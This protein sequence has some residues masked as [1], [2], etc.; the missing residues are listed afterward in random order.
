MLSANRAGWS[1]GSRLSAMVRVYRR[2]VN[3]DRRIGRIS[4]LALAG[5]FLTLL[6]GCGDAG[7]ESASSRTSEESVGSGA[8]SGGCTVRVRYRARI[9]RAVGVRSLPDQGASLGKAPF[10]DCSGELAPEM[11]EALL[12]RAGSMD[13]RNVV[14]VKVPVPD[15][16]HSVYVLASLSPSE[17]PAEL[18]RLT[19]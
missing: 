1:G 6:W 7:N 2:T 15:H 14:L 4:G 11:G 13:P 10:A 3:G 16:P 9:Y 5:L 18:K 17:W 12:S 8:S 19:R